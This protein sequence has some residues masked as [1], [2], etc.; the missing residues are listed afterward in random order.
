MFCIL[1]PLKKIKMNNFFR[2][3]KFVIYQSKSAMKVSTDGV[4]LGAWSNSIKP[5]RILDIGTG[6]ALIAIMLAQKFSRSKIIAIDIDKSSTEQAEE[7]VQKSLWSNRIDVI[8]IDFLK[9]QKQNKKRFNLIVSNPPFFYNQLKPS[10]K[11]KMK[12]KHS[13]LLPFDKLISAVSEILC[14]NGH[15]CVI[16]PFSEYA[17]FNHLCNKN[18]L[19]CKQKTIVFPNQNKKPNRVLLKYGFEICKTKISN[20]I[21]RDKDNYTIEYLKLTKDYYIFA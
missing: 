17:N 15:F 7:N 16:I 18:N 11:E 14:K 8:N 19:F 12:A 21:I 6:S 13:N 20:L 10:D 9:F 5:D 4:L 1:Y 3:K 2:F